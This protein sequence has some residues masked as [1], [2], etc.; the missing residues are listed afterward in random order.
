MDVSMNG[1]RRS[2]ADAATLLGA[3]AV[4]L[5]LAGTG[6]AGAGAPA[7]PSGAPEPAGQAGQ[8]VP[9]DLPR[10]RGRSLLGRRCRTTGCWDRPR[11]WP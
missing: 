7:E 2:P 3:M 10:F 6:A 5:F 4:W 11:E 8:A 9:E 1:R